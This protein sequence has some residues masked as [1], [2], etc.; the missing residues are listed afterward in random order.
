MKFNQ[1]L[2]LQ[3]FLLHKVVDLAHV[4]GGFFVSGDAS[5]SPLKAFAL[6]SSRMIKSP[7][8]AHLNKVSNMKKV[9]NPCD[10]VASPGA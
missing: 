2:W 3:Y 7:H 4:S 5:D 1:A 8:R 6:S 10:Q 9:S